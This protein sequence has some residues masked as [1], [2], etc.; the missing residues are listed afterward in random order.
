MVRVSQTSPTQQKEDNI[1]YFEEMKQRKEKNQ[2]K[3]NAGAN[4]KKRKGK[5]GTQW[6]KP[7]YVT[8]PNT[9]MKKRTAD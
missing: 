3:E 9:K 5:C 1:F 2:E 7:G 6:E 8:K 4:T